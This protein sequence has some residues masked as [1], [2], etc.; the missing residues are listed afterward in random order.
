MAT[1]QS[2]VTFKDI[3]GFP[4]YRVGDD[5]M[6]GDK[7]NNRVDNLAWG[8]PT[9][10]VQDNIA[11]GAYRAG[12]SHPM[13]KLTAEQ[14]AEIRRRYAAGGVFQRQL[15]EEFGVSLPNISTIVNG[16]SWSH[17]N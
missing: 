12:E 13:R 9:E 14:V 11:L 10:N 17:P 3:P 16:K 2:T 4:G 1:G 6:D 8:T 5:H 15:A 7:T